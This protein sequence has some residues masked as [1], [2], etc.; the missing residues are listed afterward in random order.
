MRFISVRLFLLKKYY[1]L[2]HGSKKYLANYF[3]FINTKD[4]PVGTIYGEMAPVVE[5]LS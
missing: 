5:E 2:R 3:F 4:L 1:S